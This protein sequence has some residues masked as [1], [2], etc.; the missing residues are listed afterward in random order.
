LVQQE[1]M[2]A[3]SLRNSWPKTSRIGS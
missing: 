1:A 3:C 2:A